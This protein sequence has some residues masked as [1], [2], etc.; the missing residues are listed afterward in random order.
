MEESENVKRLRENV[1]IK[2]A[3]EEKQ[4]VKKLELELE[5]LLSLVPHGRMMRYLTYN[6]LAY[7][8]SAGFII[9]GVL[10]TFYL[11]YLGNQSILVSVATVIGFLC[12][13]YMFY[14]YNILY[15]PLMNDECLLKEIEEVQGKISILKKTNR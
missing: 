2:K 7:R 3:I 15:I 4:K 8:V 14:Y 12:F 11:S 5:N 13:V 6:N 9:L 1:E 10:G